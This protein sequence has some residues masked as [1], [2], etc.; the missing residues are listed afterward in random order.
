VNTDPSM[1]MVV[2]EVRGYGEPFLLSGPT[3]DDDAVQ[4]AWL[5]APV[6][7]RKDGR[8]VTRIY[9]EWQP[10]AADIA[11]IERTFPKAALT[12]SFE[13]PAPG[14]WEAAFDQVRQVMEQ[15]GRERDE[16]RATGNM[17]YVAEHGE[18]LPILWSQSSPK[19]EMLEF[20]PHREI[21]PGLLSVALATVATTPDG[22]IGMQHVTY[23]GLGDGSFEDAWAEAASTLVQGLRVDVRT[24][25]G[26]PDKGQLLVLQREGS[27]ASSAVGLPDFQRQMAGVLGDDRL[28]VAMPDPDT[29]LVA[30]ADSGWVEDL[31]QAVLGSPCPP[32]ELVPCLLAFELTV[33]RILA[34]R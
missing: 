34:E 20:L 29:V 5:A 31:R 19:S 26:R 8:K 12:Y 2:F 16:E 11:Y 21:V 9:S 27:F 15:A 32:S 6:D 25:P 3:R 18:L 17:E 7:H 22:R 30:R 33:L 10:S 28:I 23:A 24:D 4:R 13:R 14:G 1:N